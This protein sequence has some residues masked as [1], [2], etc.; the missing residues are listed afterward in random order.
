[1]TSETQL[2]GLFKC[3]HTY[4]HNKTKGHV[5]SIETI[6][7]WSHT[8]IHTNTHTF[9][10]LN[11]LEWKPEI[12]ALVW[13]R[14]FSLNTRRF[15]QRIK[16]RQPSHAC[17]PVLPVLSVPPQRE[18]SQRERS[19]RARSQRECS[20]RECSQPCSLPRVTSEAEAGWVSHTDVMATISLTAAIVA[21]HTTLTHTETCTLTHHTHTPFPTVLHH[22]TQQQ[23]TPYCTCIK[24]ATL[25]YSQVCTHTHTS[26]IH[27][28]THL[29]HTHTHTNT[30]EP[31]HR[32]IL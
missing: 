4:T 17:L 14:M 3:T 2:A 24:Q 25:A 21:P 19:Q 10:L 29:V 15:L 9:F 1:M 32:Q 7:P 5:P 13:G 12:G 11:L 8:Q 16:P 27:I 20:Q 30:R 31:T 6:H 28:H 18:R 22:F 26:E 23:Q